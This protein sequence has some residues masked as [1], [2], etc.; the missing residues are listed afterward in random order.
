MKYHK[1]E[2][3]IEQLNVRVIDDLIRK[4]ISGRREDTE[5]DAVRLA[6]RIKRIFKHALVRRF[7]NA[8]ILEGIERAI[9][10]IRVE[11]NHLL[12]DVVPPNLASE[13]GL[14]NDVAVATNPVQLL[15]FVRLDEEDGNGQIDAEDLRSKHGRIMLTLGILGFLVE[16]V[17]EA[18]WVSADLLELSH[19]MHYGEDLETVHVVAGIEHVKRKQKNGVEMEVAV[20]DKST[21]RAFLTDA[22]AREYAKTLPVDR[23][24]ISY[25][26]RLCRRALVG[27]ETFYIF[28]NARR[29]SLFATVVKVLRSFKEPHKYLRDG[30]G[31]RDEVVAVLGEDGALRVSTR[32]HAKQWECEVR[33]NLARLH[34]VE[35]DNSISAK[36]ATHGGAEYWDIKIYGRIIRHHGNYLIGGRFEWIVQP[37]PDSLFALLSGIDEHHDAYAMK[38]LW[39]DVLPILAPHR[40]WGRPQN[41]EGTVPQHLVDE[42]LAAEARWLRIVRA[43][44]SA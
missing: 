25:V 15:G 29:K 10:L 11:L 40:E 3:G 30:R 6:D 8:E 43:R 41:E 21:V 36:K 23:Y 33:N 7:G 12:P 17:D 9:R 19:A 38:R 35:E 22:E 16:A 28:T 13:I 42:Y 20:L 5:S 26:N 24:T 39:L 27:N 34:G 44:L 14:H 1:P 37:G 18:S 2:E 32:Q 4:A 31:M